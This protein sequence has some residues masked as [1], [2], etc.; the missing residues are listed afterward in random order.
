MSASRK[1]ALTVQCPRCHAPRNR[2]CRRIWEWQKGR[3]HRERYALFTHF[4]DTR[5]GKTRTGIWV[6]RLEAGL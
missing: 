5:I 2:V 3:M 6:R 1:D 4:H